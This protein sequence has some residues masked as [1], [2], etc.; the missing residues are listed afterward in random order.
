MVILAV[1]KTRTHPSREKGV[2]DG[3]VLDNES[4]GVVAIHDMIVLFTLNVLSLRQHL[5]T[6]SLDSSTAA[7]VQGISMKTKSLSSSGMNSSPGNLNFSNSLSPSLKN[8]NILTFKWLRRPVAF[9]HIN[10]NIGANSI[11]YHIVDVV[12]AVVE[13]MS[14]RLRKTMPDF[15]VETCFFSNDVFVLVERTTL[16]EEDAVASVDNTWQPATQHRCSIRT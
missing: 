2:G 7:F 5:S 15:R 8:H 11:E 6:T 1:K 4:H 3:L 12:C 16:M 14:F 10:N 9:H 13:T